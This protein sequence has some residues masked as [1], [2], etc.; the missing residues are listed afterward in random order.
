MGYFAARGDFKRDID[1]YSPPAD[2]GV[3]RV[4]EREFHQG[5]SGVNEPLRSTQREAKNAFKNQYG[6]NSELRITLRTTT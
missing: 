2:A 3:I 5:K 4:P 1:G 6:R